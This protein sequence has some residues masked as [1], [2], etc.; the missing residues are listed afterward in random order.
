MYIFSLAL[1]SHAA[2]NIKKD[3]NHKWILDKFSSIFSPD[4]NYKTL[5]D[6]LAECKGPTIPPLEMYQGE[7][8]YLNSCSLLQQKEGVVQF[9]TLQLASAILLELK[10]RTIF[11]IRNIKKSPIILPLFQL[12][13]ILSRNLK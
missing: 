3:K 12:S 13:E 2:S 9:Y 5:R 6:R 11:K 8:V 1:N 4:D 10:V 7:L